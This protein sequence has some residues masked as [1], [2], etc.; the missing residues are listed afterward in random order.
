M[1][2]T[3]LLT[4]YR[5]GRR[6]PLDKLLNSKLLKIFQRGVFQTRLSSFGLLLPAQDW[7]EG[8]RER[9]LKGDFIN[10]GYNWAS[11]CRE[12]RAW[13]DAS[14]QKVYDEKCDRFDRE[15]A[16]EADM[17]KKPVVYMCHAGLVDYALPVLLDH[18][19]VA[20][21]FAGQQCPVDGN[22]WS[23]DLLTD[24]ATTDSIKGTKNA[25]EET[26]T[27]NAN[28]VSGMAGLHPGGRMP[29]LVQL[30][31]EAPEISPDDVHGILEE[32]NETSKQLSQLA[33][34]IIGY[35]QDII[36]AYFTSQVARLLP[37]SDV[38]FWH[39]F[40]RFLREWAEFY[41]RDYAVFYMLK[42]PT[43]D[44]MQLCTEPPCGIASSKMEG[45]ARSAFYQLR[46]DTRKA[47]PVL[48]TP[49]EAKK[50]LFSNNALFESPCY[51]IPLEVNGPLGIVIM[52]NLK[53]KHGQE[54][55]DRELR[56]I[57]QLFEDVSI[58]LETRRQFLSRDLY[59]TDLA[60]EIKSPI[61][62]VLAAA[63]NLSAGRVVHDQIKMTAD[64]ILKRLR[65]L[66]DNV[67][68]FRMLERLLSN[69]ESLKKARVSIYEVAKECEKDLQEFA[70]ERYMRLE[71]KPE[72][73]SLSAI[74]TDRD[75]F[76]HAL[77]NV[78]HNAIKYGDPGTEVVVEGRKTGI[79]IKVDVGDIGIPISQDEMKLLGQR[80]FRTNKARMRDP[81]GTGIGFTI[82]DR[83][84][85]LMGGTFEVQ[86]I[87]FGDGRDHVIISMYLPI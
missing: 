87:S 67:D 72:L 10:V 83:F 40:S 55:I 37:E 82:I 38:G 63:E 7:P 24:V 32:M 16:C 2:I 12:L 69:P 36:R 85:K 50:I 57:A 26:T 60:H 75:A 28:I 79:W 74:Y 73:N 20:V 11:H 15:K 51:V 39:G 47:M 22:V 86:S 46:T 25:R 34:Q 48:L 42:R 80:N 3:E 33:E 78:I 45:I 18:Q 52:G 70:K 35:H 5:N 29:D 30:S 44:S 19:T 59:V 41:E 71:V 14:G 84:L 81:T 77:A 21:L 58:I 64:A 13:E 4:W 23:E 65:R 56:F 1:E 9:W 31:L 53:R 43:D 76:K 8:S 66:R 17:L 6:P 61:A 68:R 49:S 62:A 54:L 27:R